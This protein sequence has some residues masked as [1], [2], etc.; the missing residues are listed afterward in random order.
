MTYVGGLKLPTFSVCPLAIPESCAHNIGL[1]L[2][3]IIYS[4]HSTNLSVIKNGVN[5]LC[6]K[7]S[8]WYV[9]VYSMWAPHLNKVTALVS[10]NP[11]IVIIFMKSDFIA[12]VSKIIS[13]I[14]QFG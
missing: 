8:V 1:R 7:K 6:W 14:F 5:S 4:G 12:F 2:L 9:C 3:I 11:C 13:I 10:R